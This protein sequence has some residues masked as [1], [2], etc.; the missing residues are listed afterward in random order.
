MK[1]K[2]DDARKLIVLLLCPLA[3]CGCGGGDD[4]LKKRGS[5]SGVV[6]FD[7]EPVEE[8]QIIFTPQGKE[9]NVAGAMIEDGAYS[10]PREKGPVAGPH[11]VSITA[12]RKTGQKKKAPVPAPPGEMI[13][14]REEYIP[15]K[16]NRQTTLS[17]EIEVGDNPDV[18]FE[19]TKD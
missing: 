19:L 1:L 15:A 9:G 2:H 16:Y 18:D 11:S 14:L 8:G 13:E 7:G 17:V 4:L 3:C 5:V 12:S 10:I 6:S